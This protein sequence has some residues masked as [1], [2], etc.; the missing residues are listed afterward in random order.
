MDTPKRRWIS[1]THGEVM[2]WDGCDEA[3]LGIGMRCGQK[4]VAVYSHDR[5]VE[6]FAQ[7]MTVEEA[8]EWV[9]VNILGAWVGE[10]TPIIVDG[11][12][13][14]RILLSMYSDSGDDSEEVARLRAALE[15]IAA[16]NDEPYARDFANDILARRSTP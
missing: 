6:A 9:Q 4:P 2:L 12:P 11:V 15:Q 1:E 7:G 3:L 14:E 8:T 13:P 16:N 5:L 10:Q